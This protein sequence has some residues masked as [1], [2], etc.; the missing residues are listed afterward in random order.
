MNEGQLTAFTSHRKPVWRPGWP[1]DWIDWPDFGTPR[2]GVTVAAD[3]R[4]R[5]VETRGQRRWI[6]WFTTHHR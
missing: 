2:D 3:Y 6:T 1:A 5:A 4:P